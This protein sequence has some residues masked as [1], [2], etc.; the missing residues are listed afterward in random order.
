MRQDREIQTLQRNV[1]DISD[2][3]LNMVNTVTVLMANQN[4]INKR[5][6]DLEQL[7]TGQE[8][9]RQVRGIGDAN[10]DPDIGYVGCE[11]EERVT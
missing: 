8:T 11:K 5:L 4:N 3:L 2:T 6:E 1:Q 9:L 10:L 7:T